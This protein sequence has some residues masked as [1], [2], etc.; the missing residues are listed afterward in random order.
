MMIIDKIKNIFGQEDNTLHCY[1]DNTVVAEFGEI[2][3]AKKNLP[4]WW[5]ELPSNFIHKPYNFSHLPASNTIF[6]SFK[7]SI[8]TIKHCPAIQGLFTT[9]III[10]AWCDIKIFVSPEGYVDSIQKEDRLNAHKRPGSYHPYIQRVGFLPNMAHYKIH[11]PWQFKTNKL[12][13]FFWNGAYW[14]NP[15]LIENNI[16]IVPGFIDYYSQAGTEINMFLP[17][18]DKSYEIDIKYGDPLIHLFPTDNKPVNIK[19][20]LIDSLKYENLINPHI[21]FVGS[22]HK[23]KSTRLKK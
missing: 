18:K 10:K 15:Q 6:S 1:T 19:T 2:E 22:A 17:I 9:G 11:S 7:S 14:W 4:V 23:L 8:S 12:R 13:R 3:L 20:H 16:H 5:K 21:K